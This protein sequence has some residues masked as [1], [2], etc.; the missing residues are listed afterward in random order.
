MRRRPHLPG[1]W[2]LRVIGT[3]RHHGRRCRKSLRR[4]SLFLFPLVVL[5]GRVRA[6]AA[7]RPCSRG[8]RRHD[9]R[10]ALSCD[11]AGMCESGLRVLR[12]ED[13]VPF[14]PLRT[15]EGASTLTQWT[16]ATTSHCR[17]LV[18]RH[19]D[20]SVTSDTVYAAALHHNAVGTAFGSDI[21]LY[22]SWFAR[23]Y[24][25][26]V[27]TPPPITH[28]SPTA[29]LREHLR[30]S[31]SASQPQTEDSGWPEGNRLRLQAGN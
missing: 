4:R 14:P 24:E 30:K 3:R 6:A 25:F 20:Q 17:T 27:V 8:A 28:S 12:P 7:L 2:G 29:P 13:V 5:G 10:P 31:F 22:F 18:H 23:W 26:S 19:S 16:R 11:R 9:R 15:Q 21:S 1:R